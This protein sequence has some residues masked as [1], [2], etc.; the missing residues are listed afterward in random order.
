MHAEGRY[1]ALKQQPW[2]PQLMP[3]KLL[4]QQRRDQDSKE[5]LINYRPAATG[6][7][8]STPSAPPKSWRLPQP[9]TKRTVP[10]WWVSL[11]DIHG[12]QTVSNQLPLNQQ[13]VCPS[14]GVAA[15]H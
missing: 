14:L 7:T 1:R 8:A 12:S 4:G 3:D 2:Q 5:E 6:S 9:P 13:H 15:G 11:V 10:E